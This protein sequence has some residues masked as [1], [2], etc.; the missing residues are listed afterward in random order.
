MPTSPLS[1]PGSSGTEPEACAGLRR[2]LLTEAR[3]GLPLA[4]APF[5]VLARRHGGTVREWMNH[6]HAL[7]REGTLEAIRAHWGPG[8]ARVRWRCG[9]PQA[10][11]GWARVA[12]ATPGLTL[13][14]RTPPLAGAIVWFELAARDEGAA[15]AQLALIEGRYGPVRRLV[16]APAAAACGAEACPCSDPALAAQCE[17]GL[18]LVAQPW[19]VLARRL[20]RPER[21][22]VAELRR[23]QQQGALAAL[24]LDPP[25]QPH[26]EA[27][28]GAAVEGPPPDA[29]AVQ[30]L[31]RAPGVAEVWVGD[32][33]PGAPFGAWIAGRGG[34]TEVLERA[35]QRAGIDAS[36]A[37]CVPLRRTRVRDEPRLFA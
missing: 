10:D 29:A 4:E 9:L 2:A 11:A 8:L 5:Q 37:R 26:E 36:R 12:E 25:D 7:E 14:D 34:A 13:W 27:W 21:A 6:C 20:R 31:R 35:L 3:A 32:G 33:A 22:V 28:V 15:Q 24:A 17:A 1:W 30:A 23:W 19:R 16:A 18:P